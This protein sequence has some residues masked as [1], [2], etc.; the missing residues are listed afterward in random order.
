MLF[1]LMHFEKYKYKSQLFP[2]IIAIS[3]KKSPSG[4]V[5]L[6]DILFFYRRQ[7]GAFAEK[8]TAGNVKNTEPAA[9]GTDTRRRPPSSDPL[10]SSE[11]VGNQTVAEFGFK[12]GG[13]GRHD[14]AGIGDRHQLIDGRGEH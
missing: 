11:I 3:G 5:R 1:Y 7:N 9:D 8:R 2:K 10:I 14:L 13:F 6:Y 4:G 12:P